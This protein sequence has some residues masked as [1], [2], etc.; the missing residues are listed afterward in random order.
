MKLSPEDEAERQRIIKET[1]EYKRRE[2]AR[3]AQ[4]M[5]DAEMARD[6]AWRV[7]RDAD[8]YEAV[9]EADRQAAQRIRNYYG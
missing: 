5:R 8:N 7:S 9:Q 3:Q 6:M 2:E 4:M 1:Q